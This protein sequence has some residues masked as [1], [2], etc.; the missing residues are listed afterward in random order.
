LA[1]IAQSYPSTVQRERQFFFYMAVAIA[2]TAVIGFG[3]NIVRGISNFGEPW[4]VHVHG[5][6]MMGWIALYLA[7]NAL[8]FHG[9]VRLHRKLGL[10][11]AA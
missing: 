1:T 3:S 5:V 4:F 11:A 6:T 10:L 8:V 9:N 7:Q 2:A